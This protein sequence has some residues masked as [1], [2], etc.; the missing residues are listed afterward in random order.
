[1]R[2]TQGTLIWHL[3]FEM[4][5]SKVYG[6]DAEGFEAEYAHCFLASFQPEALQMVSSKSV[7]Q[8]FVVLPHCNFLGSRGCIV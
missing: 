4:A 5:A 7:V 3:P 8:E 1:M 2:A 6:R